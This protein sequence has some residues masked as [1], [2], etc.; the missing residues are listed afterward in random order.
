MRHKRNRDRLGRSY[1]L[2]K[3]TLRDIAKSVLVNQ[4]VVTT[5]SRA[6]VGRRLIERLIS[7]GK[8]GSL[9]ARRQAFAILCDHQ[10]VKALFT[11]IAPRYRNRQGGF[12]RIVL[13]MNRR[14]DNASQVVLEL[15]EKIIKE[16]IK[17]EAV[18]KEEPQPITPQVREENPLA[19]EKPQPQPKSAVKK[20]PAVKK[21]KPVEKPKPPEKP[22]VKE[23]E[24]PK[25][26]KEVKK[27]LFGK[28]GKL[29]KRQKES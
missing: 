14:G 1:S 29:F 15:T 26:K 21:E 27:G 11:Q 12:T 20:K 28:L 4:S 25:E 7:L 8:E 19:E 2:R 6:K 23:A 3:A 9:A 10:L 5:Q 17:K 18:K 24:K 13:L 16:K 22:R